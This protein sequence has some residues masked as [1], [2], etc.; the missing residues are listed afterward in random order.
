VIA[1][2]FDP[3]W[4][5]EGDGESLVPARAFGWAMAASV[6]AGTT[7]FRFT[8]QWVRTLEM[9]ALALVWL[10]ALWVTRKPGSA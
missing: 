7:S 5:I 10:V 1:D 2:Q 3:G 8:D 9:A 4:R 6:A